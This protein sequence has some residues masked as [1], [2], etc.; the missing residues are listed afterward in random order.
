MKINNYY[1]EYISG[2]SFHSGLN[3]PI[4]D[5]NSEDGKIWSRILSLEEQCRG[6][7]VLHVGCADHL[8][9]IGE[10]RKAGTWLH[11]RLTD[12]ASSCIGL[13]INKEAIDYIR[14]HVGLTNVYFADFTKKIPVEIRSYGLWDK[15][16]LGE[17]I[18]HV[19]NPVAFL[20]SLRSNLDGVAN[21]LVLTAPNALRWENFQKLRNGLE[22]VNSDHRFWFTPFTLSKIVADAGFKP[23]EFNFVTSFNLPKPKGV[24]SFLHYRRLLRFPALRDTIILQAK[25]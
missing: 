3:F 9:L 16:V 1:Y 21:E 20:K 19:G 2:K 13:D 14:D 10:K 15:V 4:S 23:F 7:R 22:Y 11:Q 5:G 8:E 12:C 6:R 18:E 17:I 25:F 24:R